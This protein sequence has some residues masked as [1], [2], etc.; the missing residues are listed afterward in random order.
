MTSFII[1]H[2]RKCHF[3]EIVDSHKNIN[4]VI[5]YIDIMDFPVIFSKHKL[6]LFSF[7]IGVN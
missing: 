2:R 6:Q 5:M 4:D 3:E 7:N 1:Y